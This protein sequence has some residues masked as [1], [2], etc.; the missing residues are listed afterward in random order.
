MAYIVSKKVYSILYNDKSGKGKDII[1]RAPEMTDEQLE[2]ELDDFFGSSFDKV[3]AESR[4][5]RYEEVAK[6][7]TG[8]SK[9]YN[10]GEEDAR[11]ALRFLQSGSGSQGLKE[12]TPEN[13]KR[14]IKEAN[15]KQNAIAKNTNIKPTSEDNSLERKMS[16]KKWI[17]DEI[18]AQRSKRTI[19]NDKIA[20]IS[21]GDAGSGKSSAGGK[22]FLRQYGAYEIDADRMKEHIPEF[23]KDFN[24]VFMVHQE[25]GDMADAMFD[26]AL[27]E[28]ANVFIPKTGK[29]FSSIKEV[30]DKLRKHGYKVYADFVDLDKEE[31]ITRTEARALTEGRYTAPWIIK[32]SYGKN[33]TVFEKLKDQVDGWRYF[34]N[35]KV[36][37][38]DGEEL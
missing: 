21:L 4:D 26:Q 29:K 20:L 35:G 11:K 27:G 34:N 10:Y 23:Q 22:D 24:M 25:S 17:K 8:K 1:E 32:A 13:V 12:I 15:V 19:R 37:E 5:R 9:I 36:E 16:R 30:V 3:E 14:F 6:R 28:G 38:R 33:Y 7:L 18:D 31:N 2:R